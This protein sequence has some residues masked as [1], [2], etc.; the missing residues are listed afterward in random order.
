[1]KPVGDTDE[2]VVGEKDEREINEE[3]NAAEAHHFGQSPNVPAVGGVKGAIEAA[4][5][6]AEEEVHA[7]GKSVLLRALGLEEQGGERGT[8]GERIEGGEER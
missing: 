4:E 1:M 6:P 8:E 2:A 7:A 5:E 3:R